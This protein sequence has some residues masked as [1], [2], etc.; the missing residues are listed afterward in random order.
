MSNCKTCPNC[1]MSNS[2]HNQ[3]GYWNLIK[4]YESLA[5]K[6]GS[7]RD[8]V[9]LAQNRLSKIATGVTSSAAPEGGLAYEEHYQELYAAMR[10]INAAAEQ[11]KAN[12]KA[13]K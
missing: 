1:G 10:L 6:T 3:E 11:D 12:K 4:G 8:M 5:V 2:A 9:D 13:A 7:I